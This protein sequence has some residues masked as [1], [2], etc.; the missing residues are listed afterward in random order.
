MTSGRLLSVN[1]A[2]TLFEQ[3]DHK[4]GINKLSVSH[5]VALR[6]NGV[7]GDQVIDTVNHGGYDKAVYAYAREDAQWWESVIGEPIAAGRFGEN[8]TTLNL[9][10]T[11]TVIGQRW[12]IGS[13]LLEVSQPRIPCKTFSG[14]WQRPSLVKEFTAAAKPGAYLRIIEE[15]DV[16]VGDDVI[17]ES[18]PQ[19]GVTLS[20]AFRARTGAQELIPL[21]L[22]ASE[23]PLTWREWAAKHG[24]DA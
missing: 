16:G 17:I 6:D 4:S 18:T 13:A 23:L 3:H 9:D 21:L 1:I 22:Q 2:T 11:N 20:Q 19:H 24:K 12:R 8:L 7:E 10:L 14:F 15:G 5:R